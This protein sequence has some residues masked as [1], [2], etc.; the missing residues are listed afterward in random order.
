MPQSRSD[1]FRKAAVTRDC[2]NPKCPVTLVDH[3]ERALTNT[4][5]GSEDGDIFR[6]G[7]H[8]GSMGA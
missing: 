6:L 2:P 4:A 7:G 1:Q 5:G 3:I 8:T